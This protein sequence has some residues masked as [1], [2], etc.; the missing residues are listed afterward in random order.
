MV[1]W[2]LVSIVFGHLIAAKGRQQ[3][4]LDMAGC[5]LC[6]YQDLLAGC[7]QFQQKSTDPILEK[8]MVVSVRYKQ[9]SLC[10][11]LCVFRLR[12]YNRRFKEEI[13]CDH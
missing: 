7:Q 1:E 6:R 5:A 12:V 8:A 10:V 4:L 13:L 9:L 11:L 2:L 3:R